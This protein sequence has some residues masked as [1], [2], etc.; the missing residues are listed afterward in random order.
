MRILTAPCALACLA[1]ASS[2]PAQAQSVD[3]QQ[4]VQSIISQQIVA[5]E[6]DDGNTAYSLAAPTLKQ[7]FPTAEAFM[8]IVRTGYMPI[9]RPRSYS[10]D[11]FKAANG[12]FVQGVEVLGQDGVYWEALFRLIRQNDGSWKIAGC[13]LMKTA[14]M[15]A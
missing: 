4:Q 1:L 11:G 12:I 15:S 3:D 2:V 5:F 13:L 8:A 9:Y 6:H 14:A 10:F 7:V